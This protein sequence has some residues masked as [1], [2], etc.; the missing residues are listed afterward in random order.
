MPNPL[1]RRDS[2][3]QSQDAR[4]ELDEIKDA[5]TRLGADD[6][7]W[8]VLVD[9]EKRHGKWDVDDFLEMGRRE[10]DRSLAELQRLAGPPVATARA[11]DFGCGAGRLT[12]SLAAHYDAVTGVDISPSMLV[13][14]RSLDRTDGR[15]TFVLNDA[16]DLALVEDE[17]I[18]LVFTSLVLQHMPPMLADI[19]LREFGRILRPGGAAI[20]LVPT[21]TRMTVQGTLFRFAPRQV[22]AALQT[23]LRGYPAPMQMHTLPVAHARTVLA[24][25]GLEVRGTTDEPEHGA[26]WDFTRFYAVKSG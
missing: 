22:V 6:P 13:T 12:Q 16:S 17:Q 15:C 2:A 10:V 25:A 24:S 21:A 20:V 19:Y 7:L 23:R 5:W 18:D 9:P 8:A 26:H 4:Q 14:A 3:S 1:H 11:L